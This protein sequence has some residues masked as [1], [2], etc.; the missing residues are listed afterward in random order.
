M[1]RCLSIFSTDGDDDYRDVSALMNDYWRQAVES[2]DRARRSKAHADSL[3]SLLKEET[4][5]TAALV[6]LKSRSQL[7]LLVS[8]AG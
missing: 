1:Q 2:R 6:D 3:T 8:A 5:K 7:D 4:R